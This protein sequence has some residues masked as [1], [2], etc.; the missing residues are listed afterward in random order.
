MGDRAAEWAFAFCA[1]DIDMDPLPIA[2]AGREL[3]E[4]VLTDR[5]PF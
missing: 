4:A 1:F 2:G 5:N 3:I